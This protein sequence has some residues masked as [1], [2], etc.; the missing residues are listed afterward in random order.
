MG[1]TPTLVSFNVPQ[2]RVTQIAC[3]NHH[4]VV[5]TDAGEVSELIFRLALPYDLDYRFALGAKTPVDKL[6]MAQTSISRHLVM[7]TEA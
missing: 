3:G 7:S 4:S 2:L 1:L 5:L 6:A